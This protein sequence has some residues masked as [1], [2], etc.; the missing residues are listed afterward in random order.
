MPA[1]GEYPPQARADHA[2]A[3]ADGPNVM[4]IFGG[5]LTQTRRL[6][7]ELWAYYP[8]SNL[9]AP[10][11]P[12][13]PAASQLPGTSAAGTWVRIDA[14]YASP[15][16]PPPPPMAPPGLFN[17]TNDPD[18]AACAA[19]DPLEPFKPKFDSNG[20]APRRSAALMWHG[21]TQRLF[22]YGGR[23]AATLAMGDM[24]QLDWSTK[25]WA[26]LAPLLAGG[27]TFRRARGGRNAPPSPPT[28][29]GQWEGRGGG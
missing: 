20:P 5:I 16:Y 7:S 27:A 26:P 23:S 10:S 28:G 15:N 17:C 3:W 12:P 1:Y 22:L 14:G 29:Q 11:P 4:L 6:S 9:S 18:L 19:P 8:H 2:A 25:C 13:P 24:W 21:P